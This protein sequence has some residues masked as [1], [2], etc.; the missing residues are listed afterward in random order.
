[1]TKATKEK[2][3]IELGHFFESC[4][5]ESS[6]RESIS[7][8]GDLKVQIEKGRTLIETVHSYNGWFTPDSIKKSFKGWSIALEEQKVSSWLKSYELDNSNSHKV[9]V[10][11]A[12]NI[13]LVGLHDALCV[14]LAGHELHAKLSSKDFQLMNLVLEVISIL[15][16]EWK[17]KIIITEQL[18][19]IDT[20]IATGSDNSARYFEYY[21]KDKKRLLRKNRTSVGVLDGKESERELEGLADDIFTYFGLGCRNITKVFVPKG[22]NLD[23]IFNALFAYKEVGN[24]NKYANNYDYNK[25]VYLLNKIELV[26]NGFILLKEDQGLHSPVGVLFYEYYEDLATVEK[27]LNQSEEELQCIVGNQSF[28]DTAFG[29]AQQPEL[30]DYADN[31]DT[32]KF[33]LT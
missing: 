11:M 10:I 13:P 26:E 15:S 33:L 25:A 28:C 1:M 23:L 5:L 3:L 19:T 9:G 16:K 29:K 18:K 27:G 22:Y 17:E 7:Q 8:E 6:E 12:G 20:L 30:W 31:V 14:L 21:F 32:L 24:H 2:V 4:L